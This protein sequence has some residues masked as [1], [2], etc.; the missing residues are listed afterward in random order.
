MR[1]MQLPAPGEENAG[2]ELPKQFKYI[3]KLKALTVF[4]TSA[5]ITVPEYKIH[6]TEKSVKFLRI[7]INLKHVGNIA[8]YYVE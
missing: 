6:V 7:L 3:G 2:M 5:D 8:I 1:L 4:K